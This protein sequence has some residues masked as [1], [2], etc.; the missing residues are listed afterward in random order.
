MKSNY[1][2]RYFAGLLLVFVLL[3]T[4]CSSTKFVCQNGDVVDDVSKCNA[5]AEPTS[6]AEQTTTSANIV[7]DAP[8]PAAVP[9]DFNKEIPQEAAVPPTFTLTDAQKSKIKEMIVNKNTV[10]FPAVNGV[11][12]IIKVGDSFTYAFG[13]QNKNPKS[14]KF[15]YKLELL[16]AKTESL[17]TGGADGSVINWFKTNT[18]LDEQYILG[19]S[20]IA[21]IPLVVTVGPSINEKGEPT[22]AGTYVFRISTETI[23]EPF[24]HDYHYIDFTLR[25]SK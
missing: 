25:V 10:I 5:A 1:L 14:A 6:P 13:I 20:E 8:A 2:L 23:E 4:A 21:Y 17:S 19:K 24:T 12:E 9:T 7:P 16:S 18:K 15:G 22:F 3:L 11:N